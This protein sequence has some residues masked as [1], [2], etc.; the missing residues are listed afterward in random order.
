MIKDI[1][2][3]TQNLEPST[4]QK[5]KS[6]VCLR[7]RFL[8]KEKSKFDLRNNILNFLGQTKIKYANSNL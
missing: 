3:R 5:R 2:T 1:N 8:K 4:R 7:H 6:S